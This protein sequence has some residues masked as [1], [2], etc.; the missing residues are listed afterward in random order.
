[1][2]SDDD[3]QDDY[4][5]YYQDE[6]DDIRGEEELN[7]LAA[8]TDP[9]YHDFKCLVDSTDVLEYIN[10]QVVR[11]REK[12]TFRLGSKVKD[13]SADTMRQLLCASDWKVETAVEKAAPLTSQDPK[14]LVRRKPDVCSTCLEFQ[15][16]MLSAADC[17]HIFCCQCWQTHLETQI[18]QGQVI[19]VPC[20][21]CS[22]PI[23]LGAVKELI[24]SLPELKDKFERFSIQEFVES[25]PCLR[26]CGGRGCD[27]VFQVEQPSM[28]RVTCT[29]CGNNSCF[30]CGS[31]YHCPTDCDTIKKWSSKCKD[32]SETAHYISANTK[33][34]PECGSNI[35]KNGGCNHMSCSKCRYD[36]CWMCM[37][38]WRSHATEYYECSKYKANP[39]K[40]DQ[41]ETSMAKEA[42]KKYLHYFGRW[43][44][45]DTS[46]KL[47]EKNLEQINEKISMKV[48]EGKSSWIDWQFIVEAAAQLTKCRYT[49][50]YTYPYAY[51][52]GPGP[53]K[54]LFEYQQ[55]Q[56]ERE[57]ENLSWKV[58]RTDLE[59]ADVADLRQQMRVTEVQRQNLL[60]DFFS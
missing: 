47:E 30:K 33:P 16:N 14:G 17:G 37:G 52:M 49:L 9:E 15:D 38:P 40:Y 34:C 51:Y 18:N 57:I 41:N 39:T 10:G 55:A 43:D 46:L 1:M 36:F 3:V 54:T 59:S 60:R 20:M 6:E 4:A 32:D 26:W 28:K 22:V 23:P 44:N 19:S 8:N 2:Y 7:E 50:K 31:T 48:N 12:L 24:Q 25:H 45:H 5:Y 56:L 29:K 11:T 21:S 27:I 13:W 58:E 53:R 42:L 35:E